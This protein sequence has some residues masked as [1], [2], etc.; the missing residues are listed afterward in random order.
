MESSDIWMIRNDFD[1]VFL[2]KENT[3]LGLNQVIQ[4]KLEE[5]ILIGVSLK[6]LLVIRKNIN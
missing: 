4:E 1:L 5:N 2:T 3:I 6:K